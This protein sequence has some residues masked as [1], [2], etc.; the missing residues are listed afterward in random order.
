[1]SS[2]KEL[3]IG[4]SS[5]QRQIQKRCCSS[6]LRKH[7]IILQGQGVM[8]PLIFLDSHL[9]LLTLLSHFTKHKIGTLG[10]TGF[11]ILKTTATKY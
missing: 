8:T 10:I 1:M 3:R 5:K 11:R 4:I 7:E 2:S 9:P 6:T